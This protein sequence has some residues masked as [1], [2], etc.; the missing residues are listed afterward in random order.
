MVIGMKPHN[1][2]TLFDPVKRP[3][4]TIALDPELK[5]YKKQ[6]ENIEKAYIYLYGKNVRNIDELVENAYEDL[7]RQKDSWESRAIYKYLARSLTREEIN[8]AKN[9][10]RKGIINAIIEHISEDY[11]ECAEIIREKFRI[12]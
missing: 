10:I 1:Y 9:N 8:E 5:H 11:P 3:A 4:L 6:R 2:K 7:K 12:R